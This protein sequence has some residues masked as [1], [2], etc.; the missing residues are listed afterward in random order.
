MALGDQVYPMPRSRFSL[1]SSRR[2]GSIALSN[3]SALRERTRLLRQAERRLRALTNTVPGVVIQFLLQR[4][5]I[6]QVEF[7][8]RGSYELLGLASQQI[9]RNPGQALGRLDQQDRRKM[10]IPMLEMLQAGQPFSYALRYEHRA[11]APA[12]CSS[13]TGAQPVRA[14]LAGVRVVQDV[15]TRVEQEQALQASH[16][17][18]EQ[19]VLA[20][21]RFLAA[22]SHEIRTPMNAILGLLEWLSHTSLNAEQRSALA[23]VRQAGTSCWACS[24]TCWISAATRT[25][26]WRS[27]CS[28]LIWWICASTWRP[29]TGPKPAPSVC[30]CGWISII[31]CPPRWSWI[32]TGCSRC[33]T[34]CW[35]MPSSSA[36]VARWC[37]GPAA[38]A[39]SCCAEWMTRGPASVP[40]CCRGCSCPL[41][42]AGRRVSRGPRAP[43]SDLPSV[44]S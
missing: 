5:G 39:L 22:V 37:C 17:R 33:C 12:G 36:P 15:T 21:G 35:P 26:S 28:P 13:T 7:I 19:A 34:T 44:A 38:L 43:G 25:D 9:R 14:G 2:R 27:R 18:A 3:I 1:A 31:D 24:T 29:C 10:Q 32:R 23:H 20:K 41:S 4:E 42:R 6:A 16:E 11:R 30:N 8:S 40:S